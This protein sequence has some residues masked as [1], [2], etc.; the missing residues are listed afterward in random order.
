MFSLY[1]HRVIG[2]VDCKPLVGQY[3]TLDECASAVATMYHLD[4]HVVG[5]SGELYKL[6]DKP[7]PTDSD[8]VVLYFALA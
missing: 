5:P 8:Y 7:D 1:V 3:A 6:C 2:S 4:A